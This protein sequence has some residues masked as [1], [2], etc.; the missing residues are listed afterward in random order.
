M[1]NDMVRPMVRERSILEG[2]YFHI[3]SD[4]RL[5]AEVQRR[6][7]V[8]RVHQPPNL[9][10]FVGI[11]TLFRYYGIRKFWSENPRVA[12]EMMDQSVYVGCHYDRTGVVCGPDFD[13]MHISIYATSAGVADKVKER[14]DLRMKGRRTSLLSPEERKG[15]PITEHPDVV[16]VIGGELFVQAPRGH[17]VIQHDADYL[18][19]FKPYLDAARIQY[20]EY[21]EFTLVR[22]FSKSALVSPGVNV[23]QA[24]Q[25]VQVAFESAP[26]MR[27]LVIH[28]DGRFGATVVG[29]DESLVDAVC[30]KIKIAQPERVPVLS[31]GKRGRYA[32][33]FQQGVSEWGADVEQENEHFLA[34]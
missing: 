19:S 28:E 21:D 26:G 33:Q 20:R 27:Y 5:I 10:N 22:P 30:E 6:Y 34:Y 9:P 2:C 15:T 23:R 13:R 24:V 7:G 14:F 18:T 16:S 11:N 29:V 3:T 1:T 25:D 4:F 31:S 12:R 17:Y 8:D 32:W